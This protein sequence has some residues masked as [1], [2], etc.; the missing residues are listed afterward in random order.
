M[1]EFSHPSPA[2][3]KI[4]KCFCAT[5]RFRRDGE[6]LTA[7]CADFRAAEFSNDIEDFRG[8]P[9]EIPDGES[10]DGADV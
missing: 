8:L 1:A 7:A 6:N 2:R 5:F 3:L 9:V 4:R 10:G